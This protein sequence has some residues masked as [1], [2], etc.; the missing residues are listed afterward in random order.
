LPA[1]FI[2]C[3]V[4]PV[5]SQ[6]KTP[7]RYTDYE[8]GVGLFWDSKNYDS[9]FLVFNRYVNNPD[10]SLKKGLAYRYMGEIQWKKGDL[11]GAQES[12]ITTIRILDPA[13]EKHREEIGITYF[14]LGNVD[15]DLKLYDS[16]IQSYNIASNLVK[17][18]DYLIDI[19]NGK[20]ITF[21][22]MSKYKE[23]AAIYYTAL[24]LKP[25]DKGLMARIIDNG[26]RT[27]W[28]LDNRYLAL[29]E[30]RSALQIRIDSQYNDGLNASYA[31]I[32]DY[33]AKSYPDSALWYA[34][35]MREQATANQS[36]DD[37]LEAI[38][39]IIRLTNAPAL[40][41]QWYEKYKLLNDSLQ[42]SRD[43]ST[44]RFALVKY[45]IQK[46]KADNLS[47][48]YAVEKSK[49]D[50]LILQRDNIKQRLMIYGV[51]VIALAVIICLWIWY[52]KRRKRIK[53]EAENAIR[54]SKLKTS[55]KVH[56]V[57]ANQLYR[58]MNELEHSK[59]IDKEVLTNKIEGLYEQSR[60]IS[61]EDLPPVN[62]MDHSNQVHNLLKAFDN[63]H[64]KV[65]IVGNGQTFWSRINHNQ[66]KELLLVFSEIMVNMTKHSQAKNVV[67][68]FK[69]EHNKGYITYK[70]DGAGFPAG[71]EFGNG[72]NNTV[73]RI[74]SMNGEVNFG[75]SEK[76]GALIA[77][78]FPLKSDKT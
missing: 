6:K 50:N 9:A 63:D 26:A 72:L 32:S 62:S 7:P 48:S 27:K 40:K 44:N 13:N 18:K 76:E 59:T 74:K 43:T 8:R 2:V 55:Q 25:V 4:Y 5:K 42:F 12:L 36:P 24:S 51:S 10:D 57:V 56:D 45:D 71:L 22:R 49:A 52:T 3:F 73:S 30:F 66:K 61:Y 69:Q 19:M 67:I 17:D 29:P 37:I 15:G 23:A 47:L 35:K 54:D 70:D 39:K 65:F 46:S 1:F 28:L 21:Q 58:I 20:A 34:N 75:Q 14:L 31:H 64:T 41:E 38:D 60:D 78:S 53:L 77:I 68:E 16:A 11:Y 33:Y